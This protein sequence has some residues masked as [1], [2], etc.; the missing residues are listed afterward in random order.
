MERKRIIIVDLGSAVSAATPDSI[1]V[2]FG[3]T[4]E[5]NNSV[6]VVGGIVGLSP[7]FAVHLTFFG[8]G[9]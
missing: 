5:K 8:R 9:Y 3:D 6:S 7:F 1:D 2:V 4:R